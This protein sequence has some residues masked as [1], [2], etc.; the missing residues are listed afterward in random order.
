MMLKPS[1]LRSRV[2]AIGLL[3]AVLVSG[4][5]FVVV[6]VVGMIADTRRRIEQSSD[7]LQL[8]RRLAQQRTVLAKKL[9]EHQDRVTAFEP[10]YL[11]GPSDALAASELLDLTSSVIE[12]S[13]GTI[14]SAEVLSSETMMAFP[15]GRRIAVKIN[16]DIP[17][18]GL[19]E[20][21]YALEIGRPYVMIKDLIVRKG[22][23]DQT[24]KPET[25]PI[26]AVTLQAVGYLLERGESG[27]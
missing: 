13:G 27:R 5:L 16:A 26:L 19:A 25:E 20:A 10:A 1:S 11:Q 8:Y 6:P 24:N 17:I 23:S 12:K 7:L 4:Y 14:N 21:L 2:L 22:K 9:S 3:G 18:G 15:R